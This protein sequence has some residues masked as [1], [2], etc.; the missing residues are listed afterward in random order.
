MRICSVDKLTS[1]MK[2]GKSIYTNTGA[3]L[4]GKETQLTGALI[5]KLKQN[6]TLFIYIDDKISEG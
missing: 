5:D 6:N 1:G 3:L 4:L 2:V